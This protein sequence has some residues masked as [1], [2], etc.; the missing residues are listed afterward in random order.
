LWTAAESGWIP[1]GVW[2]DLVIPERTVPPTF[3]AIE[4]ARDGSRFVGVL[5]GETPDG[6]V[7]VSTGFVT[8]TESDMWKRVAEVLPPG[9]HL[10]V[11]GSLES[12]TPASLAA[13]VV[14]GGVGQ[15]EL[16]AW[17]GLVRSAILAGEVRHLGELAL[18]EHVQRAVPYTTRAGMG[19]SSDASPGPIELARCVVW[20][21]GLARRPRR[22][23]RP[24]IGGARR[25]A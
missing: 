5:A 15:G 14:P 9:A 11:P 8:F 1:P 6:I 16:L 10:A 24:A 22:T 18:S 25:R 17:T 4:S 7:E 13:R 20:A 23:V 3:L 12:H 21:V 2:D 19:L